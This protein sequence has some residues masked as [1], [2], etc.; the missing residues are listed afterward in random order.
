MHA[1]GIH[2][3][4]R[5]ECIFGSPRGEFSRRRARRGRA[6]DDGTEPLRDVGHHPL[7]VEIVEQVVEVPVVQLQRLVLRAGSVVEQLAAASLARFVGGAVKDQ[8]RQGDDAEMPA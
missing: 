2:R 7:L 1:N 8:Q 3:F 4:T 5:R 6:R